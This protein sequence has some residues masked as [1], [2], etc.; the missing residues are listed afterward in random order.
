MTQISKIV[1]FGHFLDCFAVPVVVRSISGAVRAPESPDRRNRRNRRIAG[2]PFSGPPCGLAHFGPPGIKKRKS[3]M[4][5]DLRG[6][7]GSPRR[8]P[9]G[10]TFHIPERA[11][12]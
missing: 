5:V 1:D 12:A 10:K 6:T 4:G 9:P 8:Q 11:A 7:G 2:S 3:K